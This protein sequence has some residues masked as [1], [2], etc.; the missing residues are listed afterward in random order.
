[1][2]NLGKKAKQEYKDIVQKARRNKKTFKVT[3]LLIY[4]GKDETKLQ[5]VQH[6]LVLVLGTVAF[7]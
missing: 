5:L 1:M 4:L 7:Y 6:A 2:A 3:L